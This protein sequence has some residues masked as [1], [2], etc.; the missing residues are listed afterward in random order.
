MGFWSNL[1]GRGSKI[2]EA[3]ANAKLDEIEDP[4]EMTSQALRD[5]NDKLGRAMTAQASYK[6]MI[7]QF[8]T[9]EQKK[10]DEIIN[11]Q[12][13]ANELQDLIDKGQRK[14]EDTD[15]L[16]MTA[17]TNLQRCTTEADNEKKNIE[18]QDAHYKSLT[19]D[20]QKLRDLINTTNQNLTSLKTRKEVADASVQVNK[21]LSDL[22]GL[23]STKALIERMEQKVVQ[24]ESLA[25]AYAGIDDDTA[26]NENKIDKILEEAGTSP[27]NDLLASFR[28]N[29]A[30]TVK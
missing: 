2:A 9:K 27:S 25:Q 17:L 11:W 8:K 5:L 22:A 21:E 6:S 30:N 7:I 1:F 23:D 16:I 4:V 13:K 28:A 12:K 10:R 18:A 19:D 14:Q 24:Q 20:I 29:R 26:T 15:P 3:K